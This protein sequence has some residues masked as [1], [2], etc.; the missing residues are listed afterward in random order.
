MCGLAGKYTFKD[1]MSN[2]EDN[3][4]LI[5]RM[6]K[7]LNHRGPD[8]QSSW[9]SEDRKV[10]FGHKRLSILD[11]SKNGRQPMISSSKR[12]VC[13]FNGEIYNFLQIREELKK[14]NINFKSSSDTEVLVEMLDFFGL[15][16]T[17][18]KIDGMFS[19]AIWDCH[20][21]EMYL[22]RDRVGKKPLYYK[23]NNDSLIFSSEIKGFF[24]DKKKSLSINYESVINYF[25]LGY[26]PGFKT[27]FNEINEVK[28]G[29]YLSISSKGISEHLYWNLSA[30]DEISN[31]SFNDAVDQT[32]E[33]LKSSIKKRLVSDVPLGF[34]L[35]GGIDSGLIVAMASEIERNI[36]TFTISFEEKEFDESYLSKKVANQYN[37]NHYM[38]RAS[39]DPL[40]SVYDVSRNYDQPF[41]DPSAIPSLAICKEASKK[42]KVVLCGDGGD[43]LFGGYRRAQAANLASKYKRLFSFNSYI[44]RKAIKPL[45]NLNSNYRN[46]FI[47]ANK[48]L[49][50]TGKDIFER[51]LLWATNGFPL[52]A[53]KNRNSNIIRKSLESNL[54]EIIPDFKDKDILEQFFILDFSSQLPSSLLPKMDIASMSSSIEARSPFLDKELVEFAFSI[55]KSVKMKGY[56]TKP[57]LR[58]LSKKYLPKKI[59]KGSKKG[60]EIPIYSWLEGPLKETLNDLALNNN[61][62]LFDVFE[63]EQIQNLLSNKE[64]LNVH[65]WSNKI[66][67]VLMFLTWEKETYNA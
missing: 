59:Y 44:L 51:Y 25:S 58:A 67:L 52:K 55:S 54:T 43:E 23:H 66:W 19:I 37:T 49:E 21:E 6:L 32:E 26:I 39:I 45:S 4:H 63:F 42:T 3:Y 16:K 64:N 17:L 9:E 13:V 29:H 8:D 60:F 53:F 18:N 62:V 22:C 14:L 10:I 7:I 20:K 38:L 40:S 34:F 35:S 47:K 46:T 56:K 1:N 30:I 36:S 61:S 24:V 15:D 5:Q 28:P 50:G 11:L 48:I 27:I 57:I 2:G 12:Y 31:L 33:I 65:S 41:G